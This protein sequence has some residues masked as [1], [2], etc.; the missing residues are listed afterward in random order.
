MAVDVETPQGTVKIA[1]E[2]EKR[3]LHV[4][5]TALKVIE[6]HIIELECNREI[7]KLA[8]RKIKAEIES[9]K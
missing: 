4:K 1:T 8:E 3:W 6:T 9:I 7:L 5:E 2:E